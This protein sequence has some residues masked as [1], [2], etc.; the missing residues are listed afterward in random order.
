MTQF[1]Q[2][3]FK[4]VNAFFINL[5]FERERVLPEPMQIQ[6]EVQTKVID[7][8]FPRIQINIRTSTKDQSELK[9]NLELIGLF[10]YIG[11][12]PERDRN[13]I[14]EFIGNKGLHMLWPYISQMTRIITS[15]M[16]MNPLDVH[17]PIYFDI[18]DI[19]KTNSTDIDQQPT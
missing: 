1:N 6:I 15:Q 13:L 17:T 2:Y 19:K 4:L 5:L 3:Q 8:D 16:G 10:D 12:N 18:P 9:M 11:D 14:Y 7:K